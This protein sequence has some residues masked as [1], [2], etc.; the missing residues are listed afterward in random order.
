[1]S[2]P[3]LVMVALPA[4]LVSV[5][6]SVKRLLLVMAEFPAELELVNVIAPLLV[7]LGA[8]AELLTMPEPLI[9][10][11]AKLTVKEYAGAMDVN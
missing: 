8:D 7:K 2:A 6:E 5:K 3:L 9:S 11:S 1:V 10:K 4:V